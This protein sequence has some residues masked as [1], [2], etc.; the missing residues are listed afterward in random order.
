MRIRNAQ[1]HGERLKGRGFQ[2]TTQGTIWYVEAILAIII[3]MF[4]GRSNKATV[5]VPP[6]AISKHY[7]GINARRWIARELVEEGIKASELDVAARQGIAESFH[8]LKDV[9]GGGSYGAA[10]LAIAIGAWNGTK[11][12]DGTV[13]FPGLGDVDESGRLTQFEEDGETVPAMVTTPGWFA[14]KSGKR[15]RL[16]S[17]ARTI[18]FHRFMI[19]HG[20]EAHVRRQAAAFERID[21]N[22]IGAAGV[23][24]GKLQDAI[25]EDS[26]L[27]ALISDVHKR[28]H[29]L[30]KKIPAKYPG[31]ETAPIG[32][33]E[34]TC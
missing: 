23:P 6:S 14:K 10:C 3:R 22:T 19:R 21:G 5:D 18:A 31:M 27:A 1:R 15:D 26:R 4:G 8:A 32:V 30:A 25:R 16:S 9:Q 28:A 2:T 20:S 11:A 7:Q 29:E 12:A 24:Y 34:V 33:R 17:I 13:L